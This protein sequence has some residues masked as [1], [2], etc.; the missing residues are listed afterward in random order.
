MIGRWNVVDPMAEISQA[1]STYQYVENNP[2]K[3]ID[4]TGMF[5]EYADRDAYEAENPN[6]NL[7]GSDGPPSLAQE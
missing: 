7:D 1:Y 2:L 6:G 3:Y 4:P 5:K